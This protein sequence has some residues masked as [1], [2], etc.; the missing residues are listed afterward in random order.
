MKK[1]AA[2]TDAFNQEAIVVAVINIYLGK[3][4]QVRLFTYFAY[5]HLLELASFARIDQNTTGVT[6]LKKNVL[7]CGKL[8]MNL[9]IRHT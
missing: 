7:M 4:I 8:V 1:E 3:T 2:C 9:T 5:S 6:I